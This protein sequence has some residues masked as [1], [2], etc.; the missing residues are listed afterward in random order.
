[1]SFRTDERALSAVIAKT[2][3]A[4]IAMLYVIGMTGLL[5]GSIVPGYEAATGEELSERVLATAAETVEQSPPDARGTVNAT[6]AVDL[7]STID[8]ESYELHLSAGE[9]RLD[10]PSDQLDRSIRLSLPSNTTVETGTWQSGTDFQ[11]RVEGPSTNR[12]IR[13]E[14]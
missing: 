11:V 12:T 7:P 10:H 13:I 8:G 14:S 5:Y 9:L 1:M 2:F 3:A 4:A 6:A